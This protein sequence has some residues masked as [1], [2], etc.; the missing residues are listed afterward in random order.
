MS[1]NILKVRLKQAY[2]TER[3]WA[4]ANPVLLEGEVAHNSDNDKYK[5][6]N[7]SSTWSQLS[8]KIPVSKSDIGLGNV[9]NKS[10][11]TIRGELTK[12]NVTTALG[13]IPPTTNTTYGA[14]TSSTLGLIKSGTDITV[15]S[16]GNV[17]IND[18]SHNHIIS[19]IDGLQS[20]LDA[21]KPLEPTT[22]SLQTNYV[23]VRT[24]NRTVSQY[25]EFWDNVGWADIHAGSFTT[26]G[27]FIGN[28][29]G[30]ADSASSVPWSGITGK[31]S[32]FTPSDHTHDSRYYTESEIDTK[33]NTKLNIS[34][35]GAA[36]GLAELDSTG[37]VPSNQLPSYVDDVIE[38]YLYNS[39]FYK[40]SAHTTQ[41]TSETG[42]I[43]VDLTS[44]KTYRWSG[45]AFVVISE[46]LAL[47]ETSSTAY[48]GDRGKIAYDH[49]Q[50]AHAPSNAEVNQ[51]TFS[52][53]TVGS[54]T[55]SA[56]SKTD[57]LT[58]VAGSNVT[59][60]AD[61]TND[62]ITIS[63]TNTD[64]KVTQT[65]VTSSDYTNWRP[66][67]WGASNSDTEGF[68]PTT[69]TDSTFTANTISCQP[70]S[71]TIR[72]SVFKGSLSGIADY[73]KVLNINNTENKSVGRLQFFQKSEDSTINP[74]TGWWSVLR[75]QH[76]GYTNGYWQEMAYSFSSDTIKFRRN[77]N[78]TM[79]AW[80]TIAFTDSNVASASK[81][82][83]ARTLSLTGAVTGSGTFD[84]SGDLSIR[85]TVS[86]THN[87]AGSSSSGGAANYLSVQHDNE[88]NFKGISSVTE[89]WFNYRN[90]DNDSATGNTAI[91]KYKFGNKNAGTSGV[92]LVAESFTGNAASATKATQDA[93]GN[94][95]TSKYVAVDTT[96]TIYG[97]KTFS[98]P[99][100]ITNTNTSFNT[101]SGA[102]KV[103]GGVGAQGQVSA[104]TISIGDGVR[105]EYSV[106]TQT[107]NFIFEDTST[108]QILTTASDVELT[109]NKGEI[110]I[111]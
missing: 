8:Y 51:N 57:T 9:E 74:D 19:N 11:A 106:R 67:I 2:W 108:S 3:Q 80:R 71:G 12:D 20:A 73:S 59:L 65:A 39:Q 24:A 99:V 21:K 89:L 103:A 43:Y 16:S 23:G 62:K 26:H 37:R 86:H 102:L 6:G 109:N 83:T 29:S 78:G 36:N 28:L 63:S 32:T 42:K 111:T 53:V 81:W 17:S 13:Y 90:E 56:D 98:N 25:Y 84:G 54:T 95:I 72:A 87:Y 100:N 60:T 50:V 79:G 27:N 110:L 7:G 66:L 88:I 40:E 30:N 94:V 104:N 45:S 105:L 64:T 46:T 93:S 10:S 41:I 35:K 58:L 4:A 22:F 97:T 31:P 101:S 68:T 77:V 48:R 92:I 44:N 52:N 76:N 85:T 18:D 61:A 55:I 69:V 82:A 34:L 70:S 33:L 14:A 38:G 15:D 47:G 107:L 5:I 75:T 91:T 49:S 1:E 96:Q